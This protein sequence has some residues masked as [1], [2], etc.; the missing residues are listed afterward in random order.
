MGKLILSCF[1][2]TAG[3]LCVKKIKQQQQQTQQNKQTTGL[4]SKSQNSREIE[5]YEGIPLGLAWQL[6]LQMVFQ[7]SWEGSVGERGNSQQEAQ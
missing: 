7:W 3:C 1:Y 2:N 4:I 5:L 6:L